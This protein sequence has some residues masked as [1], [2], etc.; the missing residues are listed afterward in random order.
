[1]L[2]PIRL[3]VGDGPQRPLMVSQVVEDGS[4]GNRSATTAGGGSYW[5]MFA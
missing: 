3:N 1:M 2:A 5:V 4:G